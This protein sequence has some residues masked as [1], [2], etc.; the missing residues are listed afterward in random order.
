[1][2]WGSVQTS[3]KVSSVCIWER[4]RDAKRAFT[5]L[6]P[7]DPLPWVPSFS[8]QM[9]KMFVRILYREEHFLNRPHQEKRFLLNRKLPLEPIAA[10]QRK[11]KIKPKTPLSDY[12]EEQSWGQ[13]LC[14]SLFSDG[15]MENNLR[16]RNFSLQFPLFI[17]IHFHTFNLETMCTQA[18]VLL[19]WIR[20]Y[21]ILYLKYLNI[22]V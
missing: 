16:F 10:R 21:H 20:T 3:R 2:G 9:G 4:T 5:M 15:T 7:V 13:L 22:G 6:V 18:D 8:T 11:K 12:Q 1:M 19:K 14:S 17:E